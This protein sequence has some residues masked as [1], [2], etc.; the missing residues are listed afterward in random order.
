LFD[1]VDANPLPLEI[2]KPTTLMVVNKVQGQMGQRRLLKVLLDSGSDETMF[3]RK[4]LPK[5]ATQ[6]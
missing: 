3:H 1:D 2:R 6:Q 4:A 5:G